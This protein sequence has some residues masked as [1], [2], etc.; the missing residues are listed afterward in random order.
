MPFGSPEDDPLKHAHTQAQI[1]MSFCGPATVHYLLYTS[2]DGNAHCIQEIQP[3]AVERPP[4]IC[5]AEE[6]II[7]DA[8]IPIFSMHSCLCLHLQPFPCAGV[9]IHCSPKYRPGIIC[10]KAEAEKMTT[11]QSQKTEKQVTFWGSTQIL[12]LWVTISR[13]LQVLSTS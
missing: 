10:C 8:T 12:A 3:T 5:A 2:T 4:H 13:N 9:K 6:R 1:P 11:S 7:K